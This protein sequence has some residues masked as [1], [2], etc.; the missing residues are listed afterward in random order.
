MVIQPEIDVLLSKVDSKYTLC[1]VAAKRARQI[2]DMVHGVRDQALLTMAAPQIASITSHQ[3]AHAR[4]GRDRRRRRELRAREGRHQVDAGA[5][6]C[7]RRTPMPRSRMQRRRGASCMSVAEGGRIRR[8]MFERVALVHYHEIGLKGQQPRRA[9]RTGCGVNLDSAVEGLTAARA[10]SASRAGCSCPS[11]TRPTPTSS[12]RASP[13]LPGVS[14]VGDAL[15]TGARPRRDRARGA[16]VVARRGAPTGPF[17]RRSRAQQHRLPGVQ[18][19]DQRRASGSFLRRAHGP[20]GRPRA[21]RTSPCASRSCRAARTCTRGGSPG[22]GG[23]PVGTSGKVVAL[24]SAGIDSPVAAWRIMKRGAVVVGVHFSGAPHTSDLSA[25][26]AADI[27]RVLE[28]H[29]GIGRLYTVPFGDLQREISL[30]VPAEP[31]RAA[32]PAVDGAGRRG[33]RARE[34]ARGR[35]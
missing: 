3:A 5:R 12:S 13:A 32:L 4:A 29:E 28:R 2:N 31:A 19:R 17:A 9:S 1:I 18:P 30:D 11:P 16:R 35:S 34:R 24:L 23:L 33:D 26:L 21:S 7:L 6:R 8:P 10:R 14:N 15:V 20:R 27:A 25:R 22:V